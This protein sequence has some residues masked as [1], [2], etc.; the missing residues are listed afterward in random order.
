MPRRHVAMSFGM[1]YNGVMKRFK[2]LIIVN[3][4]VAAQAESELKAFLNDM[5][6]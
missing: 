2:D 6:R 5:N 1:S 3:R 4:Q